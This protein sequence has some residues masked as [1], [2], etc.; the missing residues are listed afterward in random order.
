MSN[1]DLFY[2]LL[3]RY[4]R[5]QDMAQG[6]PLQALLDILKAPYDAI[7]GDIEGLYDDWFVESCAPWVLPYIAD[8]IG[9]TGFDQTDQSGLDVRRM[10]AD[11]I[12]FR[13]RKG[14][15][16]VL[17]QVIEDVT[18]WTA[19][20]VENMP[21]TAQTGS[22]RK[23]HDLPGRLPNLR[24]KPE[25][26]EPFAGRTRLA[27][28][29]PG[30][31]L[32]PAQVRAFVWRREVFPLR[33][34]EAFV[35]T[36]YPERR[37]LHPLG[38]PLRL[39]Q[40]RPRRPH[41]NERCSAHM[42]P[43]AL[44][45]A[46]LGLSI[47]FADE[48]KHLA[49]AAVVLADLSA[50]KHPLAEPKARVAIDP[51]SGRL[52]LLDPADHHK[53]VLADYV[54]G[55][56][57]VGGG[58]YRR[59]DANLPTALPVLRSFRTVA[60]ADITDPLFWEL[61]SLPPEG[62][63]IE[64]ADSRTYAPESGLDGWSI[65]LSGPVSRTAVIQAAQGERPCLRG[66]IHVTAGP[67]GGVLLLDGLLLEGRIHLDGP[68]TLVVNHCTI[69]PRNRIGTA[70]VVEEG[71][72]AHIS[73]DG[74]V[75]GMILLNGKRGRLTVADSILDS[76]VSISSS[77]DSV[78]ELQ[79]ER[80]TIKGAVYACRLTAENSLFLGKLTL[81]EDGDLHCCF[82]PSAPASAAGLKRE[83]EPVFVSEIPGHPG[84]FQLSALCP[85]AI[86]QGASDGG[87]MGAFHRAALWRRLGNLER[88]IGQYLP[89]GLD[90]EVVFPSWAD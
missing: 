56:A 62:G 34:V 28:L 14:L 71:S 25:T 18:G 73:L 75:T 87:E 9:G 22:L 64:I 7:E 16:S 45:Q 29:R 52:L 68:V 67:A 1:P 59:P 55:G 70:L 54:Y 78:P 41:L 72:S 48:P 24:H 85:Q 42:A 17:E 4:N 76:H 46:H 47:R 23:T 43:L 53:V 60:N 37:L 19:A 44:T 80:S 65:D 83:G 20:V 12:A 5:R 11:A 27:S 61:E 66:D 90:G 35:E 36:H 33:G 30:E 3:P 15:A 84:Y 82:Q 86:G 38:Q 69:F 89:Y 39:Y 31:G 2:N 10:V 26:A 21:R 57:D 88:A 49:A 74:T 40:R 50:W 79:I 13:R 51:A 6:S 77:G 81:M 32:L 63:I 8:L 58:P